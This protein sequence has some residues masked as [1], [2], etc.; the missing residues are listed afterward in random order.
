M[1]TKKTVKISDVNKEI[2]EEM[3]HEVFKADIVRSV[4]DLDDSV[5]SLLNITSLLDGRI[6][7]LREDMDSIEL[8]VKKLSG[9]MGI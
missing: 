8:R 7:M 9:R 4:N 5:N 1:T 2:A 3:K 6:D